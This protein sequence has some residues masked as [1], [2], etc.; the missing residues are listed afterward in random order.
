MLIVQVTSLKVKAELTQHSSASSGYF[1]MVVLG[2]SL[3]RH[4]H[5]GVLNLESVL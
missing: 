5:L 4:L 3:E 1:Y 2:L